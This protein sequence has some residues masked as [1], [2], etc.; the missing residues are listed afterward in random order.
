MSGEILPTAV[1]KIMFLADAYE[2]PYAGTEG[3]IQMLIGGLDRQRYEPHLALF[4][5]SEFIDQHGFS[6]PV[7]VF[8]IGSMATLNALGKLH[9]F[10]KKLKEE[11][12]S[13]VHIFFNDASIISPLFL[14]M[15]GLKVVISRR[16]MG[17]WYSTG[18]LAALRF[19]RYFIDHAVVNSQAVKN[20]TSAH[21]RI[22]P[23]NITV[24]HNGYEH[25]SGIIKDELAETLIESN[26]ADDDLV[27]GLVANVRP[28]KRIED[29]IRAMPTILSRIP[30]ARFVL[31]GGGDTSGLSALAKTLGVRH[32]VWFAGRQSN[33]KAFMRRFNVAVLCSESEGFSN[34]IIEYMKCHNPVVCTNAGGNSEIVVDSKTGYLIEV[35][36][37]ES[38]ANKV[39]MLLTNPALAQKLSDS[40]YEIVGRKYSKEK[41]LHQHHMLYESLI[42]ACVSNAR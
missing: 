11:G 24:I 35:G 6:C 23:E 1:I 40:G 29:V 5:R 33:P 19:N 36:D 17:Y 22:K 18:I 42:G 4:R 8:G 30:K 26:L 2:N 12:F 38:L 28:I 34:A 25:E 31:V 7:E 20:I 13:L 39:I 32:A 21:E 15:A 16:D 10:A 14:K 37:V 3:Q 9:R 41:M 27:F